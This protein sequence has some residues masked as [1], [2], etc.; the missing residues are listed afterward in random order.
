[1]TDDTVISAP[2]TISNVH[3]S[4]A[5][6]VSDASDCESSSAGGSS[7]T[8]SWN[9]KRPHRLAAPHHPRTLGPGVSGQPENQA[10]AAPRPA[11]TEESAQGS[12]QAAGPRQVSPR[13]PRARLQTGGQQG[14]PCSA[15]QLRMSSENTA[16]TGHSSARLLPRQMKARGGGDPEAFPELTGN[17][18]TSSVGTAS[19]LRLTSH[20]QTSQGLSVFSIL[21][22]HL[23]TLYL[24]G[25]NVSS[26]DP[27]LSGSAWIPNFARELC[28]PALGALPQPAQVAGI[29]PAWRARQASGRCG[30][31]A[32]QPEGSGD[33]RSQTGVTGSAAA[34]L[35]RLAS[36][37]SRVHAGIC[38]A[39]KGVT[40][41]SVTKRRP[42]AYFH[43]DTFHQV[44]KIIMLTPGF[45]GGS[46]RK[47]SGCGAKKRSEF[48][49]WS[50]EDPRRWRR[51]PVSTCPWA[52]VKSAVWL[53]ARSAATAR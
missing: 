12:A 6:R 50:R 44:L 19:K 13:G 51:Q 22:Q 37:S 17:S 35:Q 5:R 15:R 21:T 52:A 2:D 32:E 3:S 42:G 36:G 45:P 53:A 11:G 40:P 47:E 10:Q 24:S 14:G 34:V 48:C 7:H 25:L 41:C 4:G 49:P 16:S 28:H 1:M 27:R 30:S 31:S 46:V 8:P 18:R 9:R 26:L 43:C 38:V 23:Q 20:L 33:P 39:F 29:S